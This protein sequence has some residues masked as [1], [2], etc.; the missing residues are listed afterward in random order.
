M[1]IRMAPIRVT[2]RFGL[3]E[4]RR[5]QGFISKTASGGSRPRNITAAGFFDPAMA[6]AFQGV[7]QYL[8]QEGTNGLLKQD[9][10]WMG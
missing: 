3:E 1:S 8:L 2:L 7:E 6:T 10:E 9:F 4:S 5:I